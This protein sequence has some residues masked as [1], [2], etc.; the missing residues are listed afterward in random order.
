M[1]AGD[2][3][4]AAFD[5]WLRMGLSAQHGAVAAAPVP[6]DL[7][8]LIQDCRPE[9]GQAAPAPPSRPVDARDASPASGLVL[10]VLLSGLFWVSLAT[11]ARAFWN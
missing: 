11:A 10:A 9:R 8:R 1:G 4:D 6:D 3:A 5:R 7:I 2:V